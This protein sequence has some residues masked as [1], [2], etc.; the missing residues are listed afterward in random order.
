MNKGPKT[1][2]SSLGRIAIRKGLSVQQLATMLGA[3]RM[4]VYNWITGGAVSRAYQKP[5]ADLIKSL[6]QQ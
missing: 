5:I 4:S 1:L 6:K 3:S 2:G